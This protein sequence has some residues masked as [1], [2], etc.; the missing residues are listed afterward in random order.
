MKGPGMA[1][2]GTRDPKYRRR[3]E[4][5]RAKVFRRAKQQGYITNNEARKIGGWM[6]SWYHLNAMR[7]AGYLKQSGHNLW[8]VGRKRKYE[9][10]V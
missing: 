10:R 4:R 8:V 7:E 2:I 6:Q 3:T 5:K 1:R 9:L